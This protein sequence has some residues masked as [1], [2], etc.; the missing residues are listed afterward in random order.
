MDVFIGPRGSRR[1]RE[2]CETQRANVKQTTHFPGILK[3]GIPREIRESP[4]LG[5]R[6]LANHAA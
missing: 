4:S 3:G 5:H 6:E 2:K 1:C